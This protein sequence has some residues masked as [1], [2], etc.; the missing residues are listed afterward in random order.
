MPCVVETGQMVLEKMLKM[1]KS[2][3]TDIHTD[4][5]MN[6]QTEDR[7]IVIKILTRAFCSGRLKTKQN[8]K[9]YQHGFFF[10]NKRPLKNPVKYNKETLQHNNSYY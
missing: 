9:K 7:Q 5:R 6:R 3:Q 4:R 2:L 8:T 1:E 10:R